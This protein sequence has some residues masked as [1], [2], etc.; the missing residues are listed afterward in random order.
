MQPLQAAGPD[1]LHAVSMLNDFVSVQA[2]I[3]RKMRRLEHWNQW[4]EHPSASRG[5]KPIR[6]AEEKC[7]FVCYRP[8]PLPSITIR[9]TDVGAQVQ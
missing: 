7:L 1:Y 5:T 2:P 9:L 4:N 8:R 3:M 6:Y